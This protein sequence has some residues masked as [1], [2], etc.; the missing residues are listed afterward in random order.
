[1]G[2]ARF[3]AGR[4]TQAQVLFPLGS[5]N[6]LAGGYARIL[7]TDS[8]GGGTTDLIVGASLLSSAPQV[9]ASC[10]ESAAP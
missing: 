6:T 7:R 9:R 8:S 1:M 2:G 3:A 4:E 5:G 10:P